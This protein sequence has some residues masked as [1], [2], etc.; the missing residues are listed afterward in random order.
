M[1]ENGKSTGAAF[2]RA[3]RLR[4]ARFA[5]HK[6]ILAALLGSDGVYTLAEADAVIRKFLKRKV[7]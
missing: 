3:L 2:T 5:P 4:S 6:D 1:R 7:L